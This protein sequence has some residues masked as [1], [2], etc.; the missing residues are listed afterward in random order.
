MSSTISQNQEFLISYQRNLFK[1]LHNNANTITTT[2]NN[3]QVAVA[4]VAAMAAAYG[5]NMYSTQ[6]QTPMMGYDFINSGFIDPKYNHIPVSSY[7][8]LEYYSLNL[9]FFLKNSSNSSTLSSRSSSSSIPLNSEPISPL[10]NN[11]NKPKLEISIDAQHQ[12]FQN[13]FLLDFQSKGM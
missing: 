3:A 5:N 11:N 2:T 4:A 10:L 6:Q 9:V 8:R 12:N 13:N 7:F 1:N